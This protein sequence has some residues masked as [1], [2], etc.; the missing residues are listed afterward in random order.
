[1]SSSK[2][3]AKCKAPFDE[4]GGLCGRC[5]G[6][7]LEGTRA[8]LNQFHKRNAR[9]R[10][11]SRIAR[12]AVFISA[13][14]VLFAF[15]FDLGL[16]KAISLSVTCGFVVLAMWFEPLVLNEFEMNSYETRAKIWDKSRDP[17]GLFSHAVGPPR[18]LGML[19]LIWAIL[20][21]VSGLATY[22]FWN[23]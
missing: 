8:A 4:D 3:C 12:V 23:H 11:F 1:M 19:N 13:L 21:I 20:A 10:F 7:I 5:A 14:I 17:L 2:I 9:A 18:A 6:D 15:G 16:L 22:R